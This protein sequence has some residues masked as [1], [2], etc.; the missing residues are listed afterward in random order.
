MLTNI[1]AFHVFSDLSK[2]LDY[3]E[4]MLTDSFWNKHWFKN[5]DNHDDEVK[6]KVDKIELISPLDRSAA[7]N[8]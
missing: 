6:N 8:V 5:C 1:L 7:I 4:T 2:L 3:T